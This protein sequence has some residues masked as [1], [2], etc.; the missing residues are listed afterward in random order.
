MWV[1]SSVA[2][3]VRAHCRGRPKASAERHRQ[4]DALEHFH[5]HDVTEYAFPN[6]RAV[7]PLSSSVSAQR[8]D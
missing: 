5:F 8:R 3:A 4:V 2:V 6:Q 1:Y 7:F